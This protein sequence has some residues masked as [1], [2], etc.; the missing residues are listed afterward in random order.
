MLQAQSQHVFSHQHQYPQAEPSW[1]HQQQQ[2]HHQAQHHQQHTS[3]AQ[4]HA[5]AQAAAAA[6][7]A[8]QQHY[9]R[10]AMTGNTSGAVTGSQAQ[11][12]A[13]AAAGMGTD[14]TNAGIDGGIS[15]E[16]RKVFVWVAELLDPNRR[17]TALMELS[18]KREQVPELALVI[19]HSFGV[20][21]ALLQEIISVYPLLNPSQ[22]TAA[23]SNRVCNALALLQCVASHNDTRTLFLNAHIPLFLY[24][25]LNTTSKS[26]PFEYLRLT[27]LGVIGALVKNDSSDVINFL[28]TTEIIPLCLRIME[29]GSELS[30]TVAIFIVQ[31]ILLD[32]TGLNY[33][34][35]TY[36]RFYAV[37]TVLSNMV[38]QL[39]EQQTVRLLKHVVRCFLRLS[40]NNR[41]REALRQCL[42]EPLRDATFSSVLRDDAATKRCLA[43]LLI[44]L[45]DNVDAGNAAGTAM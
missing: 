19:W 5:Q 32:D 28:L 16:N 42:P 1:L 29:T 22:L 3:L 35:A 38:T 14:A 8:Q 41:A 43:Q 9:N 2:Q 23:A 17:E 39:V 21:T 25:F 27:S 34:C 37:G 13:N 11:A 6:A 33:I 36:E 18:K 30:K 45:S 7:V 12:P 31:K 10:I 40:D 26:R 20:M 15:E 4:Q 24:P 44:N